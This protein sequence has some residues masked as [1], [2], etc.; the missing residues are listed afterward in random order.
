MEESYH[1]TEDQREEELCFEE[2]FGEEV[3]REEVCF[4]EVQRPEI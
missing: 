2:K 1:A 3:Q 4:E